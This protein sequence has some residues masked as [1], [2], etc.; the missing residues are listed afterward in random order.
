M[1]GGYC[2]ELLADGSIEL[3]PVRM[4]NILLDLNELV[5]SSNVSKAVEAVSDLIIGVE[6][7]RDGAKRLRCE[8]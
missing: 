6:C 5:E 2:Y 4:I 1:N 3:C 7:K 8:K